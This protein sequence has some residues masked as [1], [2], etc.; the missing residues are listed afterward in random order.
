MYMIYDR[1]LELVKKFQNGTNNTAHQDSLR[2][3]AEKILLYEQARG[4]PGGEP[5]GYYS[6][7]K[8]MD[9]LMNGVAPEVGKIMPN[10]SA[11]EKGEAMDFI[12]N[13]GWD[14]GNNKID[15]DPRGYALQEYYKQ[16]D[17]S[18]LNSKG[19]WSGRKGVPYSFD[20]EYENTIGRLSENDRRILMNRGRDWFYKHRAP[21]NS[22]WD[23]KTQGPHPSYEKTWFGRIWNTNDYSEFNPNNPKFTPKK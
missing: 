16:Y 2:H 22:P 18:K 17:K 8:Y 15:I 11:I 12:F 23:L 20:E 10:A 5:L 21:K 7:P 13:A 9:M 4:G 14:K 6:D 19:E 3:Q 1:H